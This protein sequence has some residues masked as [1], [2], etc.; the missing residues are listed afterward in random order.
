MGKYTVDTP[1]REDFY[2]QIKRQRQKDALKRKLKNVNWPFL[3]SISLICIGIYIYFET[4][5]NL[6]D[7]IGVLI[8]SLGG[9]LLLGQSSTPSKNYIGDDDFEYH[10]DNNTFLEH[11]STTDFLETTFSDDIFDDDD[12][13]ILTDPMYSFLSINIYHDE[14]DD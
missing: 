11:S 1:N 3:L 2:K 4:H 12:T 14:S 7:L 6:H 9:G 8:G 13:D 5:F 10:S